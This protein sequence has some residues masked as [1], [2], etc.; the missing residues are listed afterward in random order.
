MLPELL[1]SAYSEVMSHVPLRYSLLKDM[2]DGREKTC[3]PEIP[4]L[5]FAS[6]LFLA[7]PKYTSGL[8]TLPDSTDTTFSGF[9]IFEDTST[10]TSS[11]FARSLRAFCIATSVSLY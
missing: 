1:L 6:R 11:L 9:D 7:D 3:S 4:F 10:F 2:V 5:P 8:F